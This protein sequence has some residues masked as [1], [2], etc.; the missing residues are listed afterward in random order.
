[1]AEFADPKVYLIADTVVNEYDVKRFLGSIGATSWESDAESDADYLTEIAG[2]LCYASWE[3]GINP[4]VTRVRQG[5]KNYVDNI[6][7][8]RHGSVLEHSSCT[9]LFQNVSRVFTAELCRHRAGCAISEASLRYIRLD[10]LKAFQSETFD[11]GI[12]NDETGEA[13]VPTKAEY[14]LEKLRIMEE[15]QVEMAEYFNLDNKSFEEKKIITSAMRRIAPLGL[16]TNI[17]WTANMRTLRYTLE[18]R[19][20]RHA[21]E[22]IRHVFLEVGRILTVKYPNIFGDFTLNE[23]DEWTT[24]NSKI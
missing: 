6:L 8:S 18:L 13:N 5:N 17:L 21:E 1:M 3:P 14:F 2:R 15:W 12:F 11:D 22:E 4:N 23:H 20:S 24:P 10:Q 19:T 7:K 16:A 9:F